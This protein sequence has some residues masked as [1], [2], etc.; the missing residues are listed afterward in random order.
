MQ[1]TPPSAISRSSQQASSHLR[2]ERTLRLKLERIQE[3]LQKAVSPTVRLAPM[4]LPP[5]CAAAWFGDT[6]SDWICYPTTG[7]TAM[8]AVMHAA[9][10]L[11][12]FH[13]GLARDGGRFACI[14]TDVAP[15][16][17][18][19]EFLMLVG[20]DIHDWP[21]PLFTQDEEMAADNA[22]SEL[23]D[24]CGFRAE[25]FVPFQ[26]TSGHSFRCLG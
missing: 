20:G 11:A 23:C 5:G 26:A 2:Q 7:R 21:T 6:E 13:C 16:H 14:D 22:A 12:L 9:G 25:A 19:N 1:D 17:L 8:M 4:D 10:H 15:W 18:L 24:K 3:T